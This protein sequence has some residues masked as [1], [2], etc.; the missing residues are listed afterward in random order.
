[1]SLQTGHLHAYT[2]TEVREEVRSALRRDE[3]IRVAGNGTWLDAGRPVRAERVLSVDALAGVVNYV[4]GDFTITV[5][6]GTELQVIAD[7]AAKERQWL[8]LDPF[9][10]RTGTVGATIATGSF[11][12]LAHAFGTPRDHVLGLRV[13]TGTGNLLTVGGRVVKNVA[14]F[15]LTRL[16]T[17]SWGTLGVITEATLRLRALPEVDES[18]TLAVDSDPQVLDA[19]LRALATAPITPYAV[20]LLNPALAKHLDVGIDTTILVRLSGNAESVRAQRNALSR[21][22]TVRPANPGIWSAFRACEPA[23]ALVVRF[24]RRPSHLG[25]LWRNAIRR[26]AG[27]LV[28][29]SVGRGIVRCITSDADWSELTGEMWWAPGSAIVERGGEAAHRLTV[30]QDAS[31]AVRARI[32]ERVKNVFDPSNIL[33]P[34]IMGDVQ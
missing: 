26:V 27:G 32:S 4:P 24:A 7:A 13:V 14:G 23:R 3:S 6:A 18:Y 20:E 34:G 1:M 11:G 29:A 8:P 21:L 5:R 9:G 12:P 25:D 16:F 31:A 33:N 28:H 10:S 30:P 2:A 17:G 22:N 15:D 19:Q